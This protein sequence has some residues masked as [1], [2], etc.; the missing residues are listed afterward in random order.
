MLAKVDRDVRVD[1]PLQTAYFLSGLA[2][3]FT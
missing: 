1:P 2:I 3:T